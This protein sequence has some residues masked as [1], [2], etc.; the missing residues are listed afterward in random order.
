MAICA[1]ILPACLRVVPRPEKKMAGCGESEAS[2]LA[3]LSVSGSMTACRRAEVSAVCSGRR[4]KVEMAEK[5]GCARR[6]VRM[7]AP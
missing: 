7:L 1:S 4:E 6:V 3:H 2:V 5:D